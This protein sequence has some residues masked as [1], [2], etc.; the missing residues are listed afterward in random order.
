[1]FRENAKKQSGGAGQYGD[2]FSDLNQVIKT[3]NLPKKYSAVLF[4]EIIFPA[5]E[6]G[7]KEATEKGILAGYPVVNISYTL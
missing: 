7:I 1:M 6:K 5:V 3:L 4:R 2:V